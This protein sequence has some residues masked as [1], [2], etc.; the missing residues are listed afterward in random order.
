MYSNESIRPAPVI[1]VVMTV[2]N[3]E[4]YVSQAIDSILNQSFSD[5]EFIIIN[6]GSTD[7]TTQI[8]LQFQAKDARIKLVSRENRGIVASAN[9]GMSMACG[10]WIAR[11]D[12][13][14]IA[15]PD[16]FEAQLHWLKKT[17]A[18]ICGSWVLCFGAGPE[19]ILAHPVSDAGIKA[20]LI[21]GCPFAN[22][23]VMMRAPLAKA[24][25]YD[26]EWEACEDFEFWGR[27]ASLG[28]RMTNIPQIL[29]KYRLH[30]TQISNTSSQR[31]YDL[32]QL[33]RR[34][35]LSSFL[36]LHGV[37][38][39]EFVDEIVLLRG[40]KINELNLSI[41]EL[42]FESL[43]ECTDGDARNVIFSNMTKLYFR[44]AGCGIGVAHSWSRMRLRYD[45]KVTKIVIL[46]LYLCA[47]LKIASDHVVFLRL[48]KLYLT[49]RI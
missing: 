19:R 15:L 34:K 17:G 12:S 8:L 30:P 14:D 23:S 13:D 26:P 40:K 10:V 5:F 22:P 37:L 2:F 3:N 35:H 18:D 4:K 46:A 24:L 49:L 11:M 45:F 6:D 48:K 39:P 47:I 44:A 9:E 38:R 7:R 16:R 1:S 42:A 33:L 27:A 20:E 43:L 21:F 29:L 41:L 25:A 36:Q 31:Q 28:L 32:S